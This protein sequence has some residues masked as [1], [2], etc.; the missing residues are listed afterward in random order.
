LGPTAVSPVMIRARAITGSSKM[1]PRNDRPPFWPWRREERG[2]QGDAVAVEE[3]DAG[4]R[5]Q[6]DV[7]EHRAEAGS[8][9]PAAD[10]PGRLKCTSV[11]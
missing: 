11:M 9:R 5:G 1:T 3:L 10:R 2:G 6:V 7:G 4:D 8:S